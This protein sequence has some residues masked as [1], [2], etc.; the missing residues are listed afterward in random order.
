M[1]D[2]MKKAMK[3]ALTYFSK[4][5]L[6][7]AILGNLA[8]HV[9]TGWKFAPDIDV[10]V[11]SNID[12][13]KDDFV[14]N[15]WKFKYNYKAPYNIRHYGL[16][17]SGVSMDLIFQRDDRYSKFIKKTR[18]KGVP[19]KIVDPN[20]LYA[21]KMFIMLLQKKRP[22]AKIVNDLETMKKLLPRVDLEVVRKELKR[23]L[24]FPR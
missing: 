20:Y 11:D 18:F 5:R 24:A 21:L 14:S 17:K 9:Y 10:F 2:Y 4:S 3:D 16:E 6:N 13:V 22:K 7:Y 15:G 19:I 12:R 23:M 1:G 8:V